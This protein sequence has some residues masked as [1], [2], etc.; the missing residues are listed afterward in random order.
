MS[1]PPF[2]AHIQ[3]MARY[4][5]WMNDKVYQAAAALSDEA[6]KENRGAFFGSLHATLNHILLGDLVWL[7]RFADGGWDFPALSGLSFAPV[8]SLT[9]L[10]MELHADFAALSNERSTV[11]HA[12]QNW[13]E[14][15]LTDAI[16]DAD[17]TFH[18]FLKQKQ[19]TLPLSLC[20]SHLFNHQT[21][22]RGQATTLLSQMGVDVGVTDIP[23]MPH[24][25]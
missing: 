3:T 21:H 20:L 8:Q 13:A 12:I 15:D 6:R 22:H 1:L 9:G 19:M 16:I 17:L 25:I 23:A 4:N 14:T 2:R 7:S 5:T 11:D 18:H 24:Q 10:D